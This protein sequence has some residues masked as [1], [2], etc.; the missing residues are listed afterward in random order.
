MGISVQAIQQPL[1]E[2]LRIKPCSLCTFQFLRLTTSANQS[3]SKKNES[4]TKAGRWS[5]KAP[6]GYR[7]TRDLDNKPLIVPN[8]D[9][10]TIKL[11][12]EWYSKG[13]TQAEIQQTKKMGL[14]ASKNQIS[15]ILRSVVIW[16][17]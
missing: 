7:N 11:I 17:K 5:R 10:K 3:R 15:Y 16:V 4:C 9:A 8:E 1:Y 6:Y 13:K 12:F 2:Y 14:K